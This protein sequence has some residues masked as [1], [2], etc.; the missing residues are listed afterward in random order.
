M[1]ATAYTTT[2]AVSLATLA[3]AYRALAN[4]FD[5][6]AQIKDQFGINVVLTAIV[7]NGNNTVSFTFNNPLPNAGA[8]QLAHLGIA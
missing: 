1:A 7:L 4:V 5:H 8:D 6:L 2:Q 3:P